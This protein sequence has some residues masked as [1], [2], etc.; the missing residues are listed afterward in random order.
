MTA[1]ARDYYQHGTMCRHAA[2][3]ESIHLIERCVGVSVSLNTLSFSQSLL[4]S[5][6]QCQSAILSGVVIVNV[7]VSF[8]FHREGH[9]TVFGE[10]CEHL[11][12]QHLLRK[13]S[14]I[15]RS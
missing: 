11:F 10:R 5:R 1:R 14:M 15:S 7:Q 12:S 3:P 6:S 13:Q 8:T 2:R 9:A 4:E